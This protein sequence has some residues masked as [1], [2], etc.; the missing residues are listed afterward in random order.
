MPRVIKD[1]EMP[2]KQ[3][4]SEKKSVVWETEKV[5]MLSTLGTLSKLKRKLF[6]GN[7]IIW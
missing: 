5:I 3:V 1:F 2:T 7:D 4:I 6:R